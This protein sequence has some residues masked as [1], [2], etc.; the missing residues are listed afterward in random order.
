M[1]AGF[2]IPLLL[3]ALFA[4]D[5]VAMP[6]VLLLLVVLLL[7]E[8]ASL[9][10]F[11]NVVL[12][13]IFAGVGGIMFFNIT[14]MTRETFF[15]IFGHAF[16]FALYTV[17]LFWFICWVD[18]GSSMRDFWQSRK[19]NEAPKH[20]STISVRISSASSIA[21]ASLS[22]GCI[23]VIVALCI[24][25]YGL[26][27]YVGPGVLLYVLGVA[28]ATDTGAYFAGRSFGTKP[29][30]RR[31]SPKKTVEG[32]IGGCIAGTTIALIFGFAWLKIKMGW[33]D[34]GVVLMAI[35]IPITA[36]IGDL[37]ESMLKRI[38]EAKE[39]GSILPGHGG[40]L[41][42]IDSLVYAAPLTFAVSVLFGSTSE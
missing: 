22:T 23:V 39:S 41:D 5:G 25:F 6:F 8:C 21:R 9:L 36:V 16:Y 24:A 3:L 38:S 18:W 10:Q 30:S 32:T 35:V 12:R 2:G 26:H 29:L 27:A 19:R 42:R 40:L 13:V 1:T 31:I 4:Y 28:W 14:T 15:T 17:L 20:S 34:L 7:W 33:T 37:V 11:Q